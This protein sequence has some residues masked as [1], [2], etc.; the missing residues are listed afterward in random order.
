MSVGKHLPPHATPSSTMY[1]STMQESRIS[2][3]A[4]TVQQ[5]P[6]TDEYALINITVEKQRNETASNNETASEW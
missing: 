4:Q 3:E 5:Y 1:H 2:V 6:Q